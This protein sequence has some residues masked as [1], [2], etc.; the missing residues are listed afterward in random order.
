[1]ITM[2]RNSAT[3]QK[4]ILFDETEENEKCPAVFLNAD[5]DRFITLIFFKDKSTAFNFLRSIDF[6][7]IV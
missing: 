4:V 2:F 5:D 1:M 3:S 7:Q 6:I